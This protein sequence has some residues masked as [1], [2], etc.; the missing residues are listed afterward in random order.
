MPMTVIGTDSGLVR[1]PVPVRSIRMGTAERYEVVIDFSQLATGTKVTLVNTAASDQMR[2]VM[3][4]VVAGRTGPS[5]RVPSP[6]AEPDVP[7]ASQVVRQRSFRFERSDGQWV[8]NGLP[9][10]N[11]VVAAVK[12]NTTER[13]I[14]E[15]DSGGW[16]HPVHVHLVDFVITSRNGRPAFAFENGLKDTAYVGPDERLELLMRFRP[17]VRVDPAQPVLGKYVMHCHN[18]VHEDHAM[19]SEFDVQPGTAG[20]ARAARHRMDDM[21][22]QFELRA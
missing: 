22:V 15:N 7:V 6:L 16:F 9:W 12:A 2:D 13:W 3:Q 10:D 18:L 5:A 14:F 19:M 11:R 1:T 4:F 21:M 20:S 17:A 8:I